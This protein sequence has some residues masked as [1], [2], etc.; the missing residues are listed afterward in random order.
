QRKRLTKATPSSHRSYLHGLIS[1]SNFDS[2]STSPN[3]E[4]LLASSWRPY[5]ENRPTGSIGIQITL[6]DPITEEQLSAHK[7]LKDEMHIY[8]NT[9]KHF[10]GPTDE[11]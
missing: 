7:L 1:T 2:Q 8:S 11:N 3:K 6:L 9:P 4:P 5:S 10:P